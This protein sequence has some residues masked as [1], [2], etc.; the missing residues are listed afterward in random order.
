MPKPMTASGTSIER[1]DNNDMYTRLAATILDGNYYLSRIY[2]PHQ[3]QCKTTS[4]PC[5]ER[6][7]VEFGSRI[8][9]D[10]DTNRRDWS[11]EIILKTST[12]WFIRVLL[13]GLFR[14]CLQFSTFSLARR[15]I[16]KN[17]CIHWGA[18][19][20]WTKKVRELLKM[21]SSTPTSFMSSSYH[22]TAQTFSA[23]FSSTHINQI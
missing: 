10:S 15:F 9:P 21:Y 4:C 13:I 23:I 17:T 16:F 20:G 7:S 1:S 22:P 5:T 11:N 6:T 18:K 12:F 3:T 8:S 19:F 2:R 14:I